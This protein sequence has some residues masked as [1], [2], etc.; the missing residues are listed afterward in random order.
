[1]VNFVLELRVQENHSNF[2]F[3]RHKDQLRNSTH[4]HLLLNPN[5]RIKSTEVKGMFTCRE[6]NIE[7]E[8]LSN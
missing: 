6:G 4:W 1:M 8:G 2:V 3:E 7:T 5:K